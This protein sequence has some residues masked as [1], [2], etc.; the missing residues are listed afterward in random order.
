MK[1]LAK[2]LSFTALAILI[3]LPARSQAQ[4][5]KEYF[6]RP[7][8]VT[9]FTPFGTNGILSDRSVNS[10]SWNILWGVSAGLNGVEYGGLANIETD[11]VKGAQGAG[12][13]NLVSGPVTGG[14]F[15]GFMNMSLGELRGIQ[16][17][18]FLNI[19]RHG[20]GFQG[21]GFMNISG[22]FTGIQGSG[23]MNIAKNFKGLQGSGFMNVSNNLN[24][25]QGSGFMNVANGVKGLQGAGFMNV[26]GEVEG[27]QMAGFMNVAKRLKGVQ[28]GFINVCDS[29]EDGAPIGFINI[30]KNGYQAWEMSAGETWNVQ[31]AYRIGIDR[32]YTQFL[33]GAQ[34]L[35][36]ESFYG[37]GFGIGT[38]FG[39]AGQIK[40]S[41]DLISYQVLDHLWYS[42]GF[43]FLGQAR[44]TVEGPIAGRLKWFAGPT[45]NILRLTFTYPEPD[46]VRFFAPWTIYD[47]TTGIAYLKMWPGIM[48]GL[49]F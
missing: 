45:F 16:S 10:L 41:A 26:A 14:Q 35:N 33:V 13:I 21:S 9:L 37:T 12:V 15:A 32:F 42:K 43:N 36:G 47:S 19:A 20:A 39:I 22:D 40:G 2:F 11:F 8:Q 6:Y 49:R 17:S 25:V 29:V 44:L 48:A 46:M 34:W 24:G 31:L 30:V 4:K 38:R 7:V 28:L 18:G 27:A 23:F 5:E 3:T 1:R